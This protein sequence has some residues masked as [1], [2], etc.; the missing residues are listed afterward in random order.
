MDRQHIRETQIIERYLQSK[1]SAAEEQAFEEA[2]L[3]DPE[4]LAELEAAERLRDGLK[5]FHE[6]ERGA[7]APP[8]SRWLE[9][10]ASPRFGIAAS[11]VAAV[12]LVA[13][14]V[15][16][17][18]NRGLESAVTAPFAA[19]SSMRLLP[20]VSVRGAGDANVISAPAADE[21]AVLLL[22]P[23]FADYDRYRA[24]LVRVD[25]TAEQEILH[26][27]DMTPTYEHQLALGLPGRMLAP[28]DYAIR[29]AG[30]RR[31]WPAGRALDELSRTRLTVT[32][33]P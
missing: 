26:L 11:L 9:L 13:S 23:G 18:Q 15:L 3:G 2:Y 28:G 4:L 20:L 10:A 30:G 24:V 7:Q 17:V 25:G 6:A 21:W 8:R 29:L 12:A 19:A 27:D 32:P 22:D 33:R 14:G 16:F 5:D 1:L 31:D